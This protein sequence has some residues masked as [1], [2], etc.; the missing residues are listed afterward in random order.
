MKIN[1]YFLPVFK[2]RYLLPGETPEQLFH[3]VANAVAQPE[4]DW[5]P[6]AESFYDMMW[7]GDFMP[8]SPILMN[9]GTD[10][11]MLSACFVLDI[12]DDMGGIFQ[13]IKDM[14]M[15]QQHG[16]GTGFN[17]SKIREKGAVVKT[18]NGVASG[19]LSFLEVFN[20]ATNIVKQGGK[21]RGANIAILDVNHPE[22]EAFVDMKL[23][24]NVMNNF[25]FSAILTD[26]FISAAKGDEQ[27]NLISRADG[28]VVKTIYARDLMQKIEENMIK[29]GEPGVLFADNIES[30]NTTPWLGPLTGVNPCGE[31]SLYDKEACN[32]GSLNLEHFITWDCDPIVKERLE[33]TIRYAVRFLDDTIDVNK[34]PVEGI[35]EKVQFT[36]KIGLGI[37][38][39]HS[40]LMMRDLAYDSRE[41]VE[42]AA[43]IMEFINRIA[44]QCSLEIGDV[45]GRA[46]AYGERY[47]HSPYPRRNTV[48]TCI[49]PTGTVSMILD[50][51]SSGI[52]PVFSFSYTRKID[53]EDVAIR[54]PVLHDLLMMFD[55][56]E[57]PELL[58]QIDNAGGRLTNV[59]ALPDGLKLITK[60]ANEITPE[61]HI[62]M[63]AAL[64][65]YVENN[66]SK[67][68]AIAADKPVSLQKIDRLISDAHDLGIR[69][70][71]IY[72]DGSR[73]GQVITTEEKCPSCGAS[74]VKEE[75]CA[76]CTG[77]GWS[78]CS[79]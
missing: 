19:V 17:F 14:A 73:E 39:L 51:S 55:V 64:Q 6:W 45:K 65:H 68:I 78:T 63:Q 2:Q 21:R 25:N 61:W 75:G 48:T 47:E 69:G 76:H 10:Y 31:V 74:I 36:R 15:I 18:T 1:D 79:V 46:P 59:P 29:C 43:K 13:A 9:A 12:P 35:K 49:A 71:T 52:E 23:N 56:D 67:T 72:V 11:P 50:T 4:Y 60:T 62:E 66:I 5:P 28:S 27:W 33:Q 3:R 77:C 26:E 8:S 7:S 58:R 70:L 44:G 54:P 41:G 40:Y 22:I 20:A 57:T 16:G 30:G 38:G 24:P 32:L 53:G 37:T 42:D 34:F